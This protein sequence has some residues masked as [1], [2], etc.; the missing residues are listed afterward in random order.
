[1]KPV[2]LRRWALEWTQNIQ[3]DGFR[4]H[5]LAFDYLRPPHIN[6]FRT[7]REAQAFCKERYGYIARRGD[8]RREPHCWRVPKVVRVI[9]TIAKESSK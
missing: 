1:M 3:L 4:Q 9:V 6:V 5:L 2:I 8:L 7:R